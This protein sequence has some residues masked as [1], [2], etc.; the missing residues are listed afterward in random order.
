[1]SDTSRASSTTETRYANYPVDAEAE[2]L[3]DEVFQDVDRM[4]DRSEQ[5]PHEPANTKPIALKPLQVPPI[6]VEPLVAPAVEPKPEVP[7]VSVAVDSSQSSP[8]REDKAL[9]WF[10]RL[11]LGGA[12]ASL[13]VVLGLWLFDR[14]YLSFGEA[15]VPAESDTSQPLPVVPDPNNQSDETFIAYMGQALDRIENRIPDPAPLDAETATSASETATLS[16]PVNPT[17]PDTVAQSLSRIANAL[18]RVSTTPV[19]LPEL[20]DSEGG[21]ESD[22]QVADRETD[23]STETETASAPTPRA[24]TPETRQRPAPAAPAPRAATS[25]PTPAQKDPNRDGDSEPSTTASA[26]VPQN[27]YALVGTLER[28]EGDRPAALFE[29]N[30]SPQWIDL[31]ES[32]G[33]S[34][35]TLVEVTGD[36]VSVRRNGEVRTLYVGQQF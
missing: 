7:S 15:P 6:V 13:A 25:T 26:S 31:G 9:V 27:V 32:I 3:I 16:I 29:L 5:L 1:M 19:P 24:S 10:D 20:S 17:S 22:T 34:G 35:W 2:R 21:D 36:R 18:E 12:F 30:G 4:L 14:G 33:G 8:R 11:L 23:S 28:G